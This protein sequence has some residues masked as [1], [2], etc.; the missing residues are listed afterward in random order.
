MIRTSLLMHFVAL[1]IESHSGK[2][3]TWLHQY[4][5][6]F[7]QADSFHAQ[8]T[9][10]LALEE[11]GSAHEFQFDDGLPNLHCLDLYIAG[12]QLHCS[13]NQKIIG[14]GQGPFPSAIEIDLAN[15]TVKANINQ[16]VAAFS[17]SFA[18]GF[19]RSLL[20]LFILPSSGVFMPHGAIVTKQGRTIF[21]SGESGAGKSTTSL[22]LL[23][24]GFSIISDDSPLICLSAGTPYAL[25]SLDDFCVSENVLELLPALRVHVSGQRESS[26]KLRLDRSCMEE[27]LQVLANVPSA[28][29]DFIV[30]SRT[31]IDQPR[32]SPLS[33]PEAMVAMLNQ[34][35]AFSSVP[36]AAH[37]CSLQARDARV[38]DI[39]SRVIGSVCPYKL[40]FSEQRYAGL[41]AL[42]DRLLDA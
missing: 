7:A 19:F 21:L 32:I 27:S 12:L 17:D 14:R 42:F 8:H 25:S 11:S 40:E 5:R 22:Q 29:T 39:I 10:T 41:P 35:L 3:Q 30:L 6:S 20:R 18:Y 2:L 33:R 9:W 23:Q 31:D 15:K 28:I 16:H 37:T 38:F 1:N 13:A 36:S 26:G 24:H 34:A 4:Y